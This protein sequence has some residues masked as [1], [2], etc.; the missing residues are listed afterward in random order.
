MVYESYNE[1]HLGDNLIHLHFLRKMALAYPEHQFIHAAQECHLPQLREV[2]ED[3]ATIKLI[4]IEDRSALAVNVW[5]NAGAGTPRGGF[6]ENHPQRRHYGNFHVLWFDHLAVKMGLE[7]PIGKPEDLLFDYPRLKE[8]LGLGC[9]PFDTE[10]TWREID[11]LIVNSR[12]CS[13]QLR[14]FDRIEYFNA[15]I[16]ELSRG[17]RVVCTD[18]NPELDAQEMRS[19]KTLRCTRDY[20]L[21]LTSIGELSN[22]CKVIIGVSTGPMWPTMNVFNRESVKM[23]VLLLD[24]EIVDYAP[25]TVQVNDIEA[26]RRVLLEKGIL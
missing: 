9:D 22:R 4:R 13:G 18:T 15:L 26:C 17:H 3:M 14:A 19:R 10:Y 8:P 7:S 25:N 23:R 1:F 20:N 6:W 24:H 2:V 21:T 5:K 12:P 11:F 16:E